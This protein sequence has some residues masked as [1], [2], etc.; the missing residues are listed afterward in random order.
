MCGVLFRMRADNHACHELAHCRYETVSAGGKVTE[1]ASMVIH[2]DDATEECVIGWITGHREGLGV[3]WCESS[4]RSP[5]ICGGTLQTIALGRV[6]IPPP[7]M[8]ADLNIPT[9]DL[10]INI[11]Q[12]FRNFMEKFILEIKL[13]PAWLHSD[14]QQNRIHRFSLFQIWLPR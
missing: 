2:T 6:R 14:G 12:M 5:Q 10:N 1:D 11:I 8:M 7:Y 9:A 4:P 13:I 3:V